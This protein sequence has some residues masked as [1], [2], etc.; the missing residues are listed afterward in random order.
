MELR[1]DHYSPAAHPPGSEYFTPETHAGETYAA[2]G[3]LILQIRG[4]ALGVHRG[5]LYL[6]RY[7]FIKNL[8]SA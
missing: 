5:I 2:Y 8:S 4:A 6:S 1:I 3:L 7:G